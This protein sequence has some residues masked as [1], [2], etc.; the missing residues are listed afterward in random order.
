MSVELAY[1]QIW[2]L[3]NLHIEVAKNIKTYASKCP[4]PFTLYCV[5]QLFSSFCRKLTKEDEKIENK[6]GSCPYKKFSHYNLPSYCSGRKNLSEPLQKKLRN[7]YDILQ[8]KLEVGHVA[9]RL[10]LVYKKA[11]PRMLLEYS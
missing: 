1:L 10:Q 5:E 8:N 4:L 7:P 11:V 2:V 3:Y 6:E 9:L